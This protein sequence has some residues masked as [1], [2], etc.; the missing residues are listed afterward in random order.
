M[1]MQYNFLSRFGNE[2]EMMLYYCN[3]DI[4]CTGCVYNETKAICL[5]RYIKLSKKS[6]YYDII[7]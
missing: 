5:N 4:L 7:Y 2:P 3:D 1:V 6:C